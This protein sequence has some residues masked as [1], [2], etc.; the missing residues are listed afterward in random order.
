MNMRKFITTII[1]LVIV[2]TYFTLPGCSSVENSVPTA[3]PVP[4]AGAASEGASSDPSEPSSAAEAS[5][6]SIPETAD[7]VRSAGKFE[8]I[9]FSVVSEGENSSRAIF[10]V[11][12][13]LDFNPNTIT[14]ELETDS[15]SGEV[16]FDGRPSVIQLDIHQLRS[17]QDFR[18]RFVRSR[19][20]PDN[21]EAVLTFDSLL[22]LPNG[23][24]EGETVDTEIEG[25]LKV[26]NT[27][28][29]VKFSITARDDGDSIFVLGKA[30]F[31][32]EDVGLTRENVE[33]G[34]PVVSVSDEVT[35]E[36]L[37]RLVPKN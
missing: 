29:T 3:I 14:A 37:L 17:D 28:R 35:T 9:T 22:P 15:L 4:T 32:W 30:T 11:E 8:N 20:F 7:V 18:D 31:T 13:V 16:H 34:G 12:E 24:G 27:E 26:K 25:T 1:S 2:V 6:S 36:I 21:R 23:F 5:D 19:L 33:A 10:R